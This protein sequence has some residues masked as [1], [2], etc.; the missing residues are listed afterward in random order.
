MYT[1]FNKKYGLKSLTVEWAM[2]IVNAIRKFGA[3]D[4]EV[5]LFGR[6]LRNEV[7]EQF[8][9][10]LLQTKEQ[11]DDCFRTQIKRKTQ[12]STH[13]INA[14]L[15]EKQQSSVAL[16]DVEEVVRYFFSK[17]DA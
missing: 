2:G 3:Q 13:E 12:R 8:R 1:F 7:E 10:E 16:Y 15:A 9:D 6:I 11:I 14:M 17:E 5:A 4:V